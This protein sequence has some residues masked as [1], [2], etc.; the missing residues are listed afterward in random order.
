[1]TD[2]RALLRLTALERRCYAEPPCR[3]P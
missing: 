2:A 1:L 3:P